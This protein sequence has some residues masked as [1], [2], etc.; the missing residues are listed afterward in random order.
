M[1]GGNIDET[2]NRIGAVPP[3]H[4]RTVIWQ[5]G[6]ALFYFVAGAI[7]LNDLLTHGAVTIHR[8]VLYTSFIGFM[9]FLALVHLLIVRLALKSR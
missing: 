4:W 2:S 3:P 5:F 1:A 7:L 6:F 9:F 8:P